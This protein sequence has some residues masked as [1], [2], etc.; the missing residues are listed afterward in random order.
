MTL[1]ETIAEAKEPNRILD[2]LIEAEVR[3]WEAYA[4]WLNDKQRAHWKPV[5]KRGEVE[6][7]GTR[8]HAPMYTFEIDAALRLIPEG[9]D[10][11]VDTMTGRPGAVVCVP[12]AWLSHKTAPM[13]VNAATPAL[14]LCVAAL[15]AREAKAKGG[16]NG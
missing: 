10:W 6:E 12:N 1:I 5:G 16:A 13:V 9:M 2:A 8:Y 4:V 15:R 11:R 7:G 14:A 3:R